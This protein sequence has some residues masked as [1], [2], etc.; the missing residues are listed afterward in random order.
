MKYIRGRARFVG[1]TVVIGQLTFVIS[2]NGFAFDEALWHYIYIGKK[3]LHAGLPPRIY[4][5]ILPFMGVYGGTPPVWVGFVLVSLLRL[6]FH[7]FFFGF[8][9]MA[10]DVAIYRPLQNY[11]LCGEAFPV[12]GL[13]GAPPY[14]QNFPPQ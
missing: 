12:G 13:R 14:L 6:D 8:S 7:E 10:A 1:S 3:K 11:Y 5:R 9:A 2:E 4:N